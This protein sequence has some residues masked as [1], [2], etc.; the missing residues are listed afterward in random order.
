MLREP[1]KWMNDTDDRILETIYEV[2]NMTPLALSRE[3]KVERID[4][5]RKY[6]GQR[7]RLLARAGLL[8]WVDEGLYAITET[9]EAYLTGDVDLAGLEDPRE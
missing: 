6:A 7:C 2:G 9:G 8:E 1:A 5:G 3:G 4:I